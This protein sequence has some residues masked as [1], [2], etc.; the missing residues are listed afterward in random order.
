M[1]LGLKLVSW[2]ESKFVKMNDFFLSF[3]IKLARL[4]EQN[5][6]VMYNYNRIYK[7]FTTPS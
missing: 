1:T 6:I 4:H 3:T 2:N 5:M 7:E